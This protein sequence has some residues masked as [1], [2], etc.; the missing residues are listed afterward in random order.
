MA[1]ID[2][3]KAIIYSTIVA[4]IAFSPAYAK[5]KTAGENMGDTSKNAV[6]VEK[7]IEKDREAVLKAFESFVMKGGAENKAKAD[8][9]IK[10]FADRYGSS[11]LAKPS[12]PTV[13][14]RLR[15]AYVKKAGRFS[16]A[17][18]LD[19]I[20]YARDSVVSDPNAVREKY[21]PDFVN[22]MASE[23]VAKKAAQKLFPE[24]GTT[25][26]DRTRVRNTVTRVHDILVDVQAYSKKVE[27]MGDKGLAEM[28]FNYSAS[29]EAAIDGQ[30][31]AYESGEKNYSDTKT[32]MIS[33]YTGMLTPEKIN[34]IA[35][36]MKN[37]TLYVSTTDEA[38]KANFERSFSIYS[39]MKMS[40]ESNKLYLDM[41]KYYLDKAG[42]FNE[43]KYLFRPDFYGRQKSAG[44]MDAL[45]KIEPLKG[46]VLMSLSAS[47]AQKNSFNDA[48]ND[49]NA[50]FSGN[51]R[52]MGKWID[53][54]TLGDALGI[55]DPA[56]LGK[57][58]V[59]NYDALSSDKSRFQ[60]LKSKVMNY[61]QG[62]SGST[63]ESLS[64]KSQAIDNAFSKMTLMDAR[65]LGSTLDAM[66]AK[67]LTDTKTYAGLME[68]IIALSARD[69]YLIAG[70]LH[71]VVPA[72]AK[73]SN[74]GSDVQ[75][76]F[77]AFNAQL[78]TRLNEKV[79]NMAERENMLARFRAISEDLPRTPVANVTHKDLFYDIWN[80][81]RTYE[82]PYYYDVK[83]SEM[84]RMDR[85]FPM[86]SVP[87]QYR[88]LSLMP[89][90][91]SYRD[92][93][94]S[95]SMPSLMPGAFDD[96][97]N[98]LNAELNPPGVNFRPPV[99]QMARI[100]RA[101]VNALM[102]ELNKIFAKRYGNESYYNDWIGGST[103]AGFGARNRYIELGAK[104]TAKTGAG[105]GVSAE[106]TGGKTGD[107]FIMSHDI[108]ASKVNMG[109]NV[110][111]A[112]AAGTYEERVVANE[113]A[114][115]FAP[116]AKDRGDMLT[117][118]TGNW[119][120]SPY[121][122]NSKTKEGWYW[123]TKG[124]E[125]YEVRMG[126]D[127]RDKLMNYQFGEANAANV[128]ASA[129]TYMPD[130]DAPFNGAALGF[131]AGTVASAGLWDQI[132]LRDGR[133][134]NTVANEQ[135]ASLS[136]SNVFNK[137]D[138]IIGTYRRTS[139]EG[140][141]YNFNI[142]LKYRYVPADVAKPAAVIAVLGGSNV[143][144]LQVKTEQMAGL[145]G[146][147]GT[148]VYSG[149]DETQLLGLQSSMSNFLTNV[150]GWKKNDAK[151][152]GAFLSGTYM[153]SMV[154][155][156]M[157][158]TTQQGYGMATLIVWAHRFNMLAAG[159]KVPRWM[160]GINQVITNAE[161]Q[162]T[163]NPKGAA[164]IYKTAIQEVT[165]QLKSKDVQNYAL[166][167]GVDGK[168]YLVGAT[169]LETKSASMRGY[170]F[171]SDANQN[172]KGWLEGI[173][174]TL[175]GARG[176]F[177]PDL[178]L[179]GGLKDRFRVLGGPTL[180]VD[181]NVSGTAVAAR[182]GSGQLLWKFLRQN[183][184]QSRT[185]KSD[186]ILGLVGGTKR[187]NDAELNEWQVIITGMTAEAP[188]L[189]EHAATSW[190]VFAD[191]KAHKLIIAPDTIQTE[192]DWSVTAGLDRAWVDVNQV[193]SKLQFHLTYGRY[194]D[195]RDYTGL[196]IV[197]THTRVPTEWG[198]GIAGGTG[199]LP[200][201]NTDIWS[202]NYM[203]RQR[204]NSSD[205]GVR[206]YFFYRF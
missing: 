169:D 84:T 56:Q 108:E 61:Y 99:P 175:R 118:F 123:V 64:A 206:G 192:K 53:F 76:L 190:Y 49:Y 117:Y 106:V 21:G 44:A 163:L 14:S 2:F 116:V 31:K 20:Q 203:S 114:R 136:K 179:G 194:M 103:E 102:T 95:W 68:N 96:I 97:Y 146:L 50:V 188:T 170:L 62:I 89:N 151:N 131:T 71:Y 158:G 88:T 38:Y 113:A 67:G 22:V 166:G 138:A 74:V 205:W 77:A 87:A 182:G 32:S 128:L 174:S 127:T 133:T 11:E 27:S 202:W 195:A 186:I 187:M 60:D 55:S 39:G 33:F 47:T 23:V 198:I 167:M 73:L 152:T 58:I 109:F 178:F 196:G 126:T 159:E 41:I 120:L 121:D 130:K 94:F 160:N 29:S 16:R 184:D 26:A 100:E 132:V 98:R 193:G 107:N 12:Q 36:M 7:G 86:L 57:W 111:T 19:A 13:Y 63:E 110:N 9:A 134:L 173:T 104:G 83:Q 197:Y 80:K 115:V 171:F 201:Y 54:R 181:Q 162:A 183:D 75:L 5:F 144:G 180:M 142:E 164:A 139:I 51:Y 82:S 172:V 28:I 105:G 45:R 17:D 200:L 4:G 135:A 78:E 101:H 157:G 176:E 204:L 85:Y 40:V 185:A 191:R 35:S 90:Q 81:T 10:S 69:P 37:F 199:P 161:E 122:K 140:A 34:D 137:D 6:A 150:Y 124:G 177:Y 46:E 153:Y 43:W 65:L 48:L 25:P 112:T 143:G 141:Q 149:I 189:V 156:Q 18:F 129:K 15:D 168:F 155:D 42:I 72:F 93:Y 125:T 70:Y 92:G 66:E 30:G 59:Q 147:G 165:D 79:F 24:E 145:S 148:L 91:A 52:T 119:G 3:K 1:H 8:K 154:K